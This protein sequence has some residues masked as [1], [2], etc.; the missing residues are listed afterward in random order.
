MAQPTRAIT[1]TTASTTT[2]TIAASTQSKPMS[3]RLLVLRLLACPRQ[4]RLGRFGREVFG[5][6]D[7]VGAEVGVEARSPESF[8]RLGE[9]GE[10]RG[11]RQLDGPGEVN[12]LVS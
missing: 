11:G 10:L 7:A 4:N 8:L 3:R 5:L 9:L 2:P 6:V 1:A 12:H